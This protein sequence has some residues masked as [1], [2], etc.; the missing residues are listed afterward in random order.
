MNATMMK[1]D[2]ALKSLARHYRDGITVSVYQSAFDWIQIRPHPL[3]YLCTGAMGQ[4]SSH[5]LGLALGAPTEKVVILDGDGSLL[6]N[7]GTLV[8]I[9]NLAPKNL[10]H[11]V[12]QNNMYEVNGKYPIPGVGRI[13][14][15]QMALA[16]GYRHAFSFDEIARFDSE[17]GEILNLDGPVFVCMHIEP[18]EY[19][20]MDYVTIHSEQSRAI[21][22][23]A[24]QSRLKSHN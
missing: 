7:L 11:F 8:T 17:I 15:D 14:F 23:N 13:Q 9:A 1:R 21:F 18:G 5:G 12:C 24:L 20:P 4:A 2:D 3:N 10:F 16:A 19:Y 6:M 22:R